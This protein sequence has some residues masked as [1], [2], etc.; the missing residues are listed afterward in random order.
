[1]ATYYR[2]PVDGETRH[3]LLTSR[4]LKAI[5]I[6]A[7][8]GKIDWHEDQYRKTTLLTASAI[9]AWF[10]KS[11][12]D[13]IREEGHG[14][15]IKQAGRTE[16]ELMWPEDHPDYL[17]GEL[18]HTLIGVQLLYDGV[19]YRKDTW[20]SNDISEVCVLNDGATQLCHSSR[21]LYVS[22]KGSPGDMAWKNI[23]SQRES[24]P[25]HVQRKAKES[26]AGPINR[27]PTAASTS[28]S[29]A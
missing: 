25:R 21:K 7:K 11:T 16:L 20:S 18:W 2:P 10:L 23:E 8:D 9:R 27:Q 29:S 6:S 15:W 22:S 28:D 3:G 24:K 13:R 14:F 26:N 4:R 19:V 12:W 5:D 17:K 1:M